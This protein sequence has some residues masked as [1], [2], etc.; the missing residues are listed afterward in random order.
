MPQSRML[1]LRRF[2]II[3]LTTLAV[4]IVR[5]QA[6]TVG[7]G[8][9][10]TFN[11]SG[12]PTAPQ[13]VVPAT[14]DV[15]I[16]Q[17]DEAMSGDTTFPMQAQH[18]ADCG[19]P[20]ATHPISTLS[21]SVFICK[22]HLMTAINGVDYGE[23]A[24]TSDHMADWSSGTTAIS[25]SVSTQQLNPSDWVE[26]WV[27]PF[28]DNVTL[29]FRAIDPDLQG[30]PK[31]ALVF[32]FNTAELFGT[33]AGDVSRV[34]NFQQSVLPKAR[35]DSLTSVTAP[36]ATV[37]T[38]YEMDISTGHIRFGLPQFGVWWTDTNIAPLPYTQGVVT[39]THHSY[40]PEKH[41]PGTG[42]DTWHW[43]GFSIS[44][45]VPFTILNGAER[46]IHAG[47]AT[48]VHFPA[49]AP[50]GAFL[51]FS[52]IGPLGKTYTVSYDGGVTWVTPTPQAQLG[53]LDE[54]FSTYFTPVPAG[55][56]SV[57]FRGLTWWGGDW[58]V[59]D[60]AIWAL[61]TTIPPPN[62]LPSPSSSPSA[63]P[64]PPP[65][66]SSTPPSSSMTI[67]NMPCVVVMNGVR[68]N[69]TCS[70]TFTPH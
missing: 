14:W 49:P 50:A 34:D 23:I 36:S 3:A 10:Y 61:S 25:V 42:V 43:S 4:L 39:L 64:S 66:P 44:N 5:D 52:A 31:N 53:K 24:L 70:G 41:Q 55:T 35:A 37:R 57:M 1:L 59:R 30:P 45:A 16:H 38:T 21:Q 56:Q 27:T 40:N 26:V 47:G 65:T 15:Q 51:R 18:G 7:A 33:N 67:T 62:V 22:D 13:S 2:S 63:A 29:P 11:W 12:A 54:H 6:I 48:T 68:M 28:A 69:G 17:R 8:T 32:A 20:P 58:W 46:S 9:G 60:P 19:A